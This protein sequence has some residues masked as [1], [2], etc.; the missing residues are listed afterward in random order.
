MNIYNLIKNILFNIC[1]ENDSIIIYLNSEFH[2]LEHFSHIIKK[3]MIKIYIIT[4]DNNIIY[5]KLINNIRNEDCEDNINIFMNI[6]ELIICDNQNNKDNYNSIKSIFI[7]NL[8]DD[9]SF[10][11][12]LNSINKINFINK[13]SLNF[14]LYSYLSNEK[15]RKINLKNFI[16]EQFQ[17]IDLKNKNGLGLDNILCINNIIE[18]IDKL[19]MYINKINILKNVNYLFIGNYILYEIAFNYKEKNI[20]I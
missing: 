11:N 4:Y 18:I 14:Y 9:K 6:N 15:I 16:I 3:K 20:I 1:N 2:I 19:D 10:S 7:F 5:H 17:S 13:L 8:L 12:I